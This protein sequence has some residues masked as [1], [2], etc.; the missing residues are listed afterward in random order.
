M[1]YLSV[2]IAHHAGPTGG[3]LIAKNENGVWEFPH[4]RVREC[5][6][7]VAAVERV[8]HEVLGMT[9]QAGKLEMLG[10]KKPQDGTVEHIVCGNITHNT[11]TKCD[12]HKYYSA[13]NVWQTEPKT[14]VYSEFAW[15]HPSQ[16]GQY[17][18]AGDDSAFMAKYDPWINGRPIPDV[19]MP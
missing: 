2:L 8:C 7:D 16:L 5:E 14:G 12:Y 17:E 6:S 15:V 4:G 11:H 19:R 9:V 3:V 1:Q 10:H 18:F 13:V